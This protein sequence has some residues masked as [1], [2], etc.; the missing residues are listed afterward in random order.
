MRKVWILAMLSVLFIFM[1]G[2]ANEAATTDEQSGET[3]D[4]VTDLNADELAAFTDFFMQNENN[5]FLSTD[6]DNPAQIDLDMVFYNGAGFPNSDRQE[7]I[8][9]EAEKEAYLAATNAETDEIPGD[10]NKLTTEQINSFLEQKTG[11][12]LDEMENP[13]TWDYLSEYDAW[14]FQ[15]FDTNFI[16]CECV[17]GFRTA[18]DQIVLDVV[19]AEGYGGFKGTVTLQETEDGYLFVSNQIEQA[20]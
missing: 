11:L 10:L 14:Y 13:L 18:D 20:Y 1:C 12:G 5:G 9:E 8:I 7:D 17:S 4:A 2:C 3:A 16:P 19:A 6:F 15:H